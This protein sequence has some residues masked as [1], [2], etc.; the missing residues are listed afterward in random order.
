M[1]RTLQTQPLALLS[2]AVAGIRKQTVIVNLPGR[3]SAVEQHMEVIAPA[4]GIAVG[5]ASGQI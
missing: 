4:L 5:Q 2:R 1:L 3:P